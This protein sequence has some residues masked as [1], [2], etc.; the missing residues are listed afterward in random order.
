[1]KTE[2]A[3]KHQENTSHYV[4]PSRVQSLEKPADLQFV[5]RIHNMCVCMCAFL[6][7]RWNKMKE[8]QRLM[9]IFAQVH[10]QKD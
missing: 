3:G 4:S 8:T 9:L 5:I 7:L 1:M 6:M 10:S 2:N